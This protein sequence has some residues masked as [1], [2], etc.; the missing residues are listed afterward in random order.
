MDDLSF[1]EN[2]GYADNATLKVALPDGQ[3]CHISDCVNPFRF[4]DHCPLLYH[5]FESDEHG[6]LQ[7]S[8]E[9]TSTSSVVSLLRFCYTGGY[10]PIEQCAELF[11]LLQH[12]EIY[13]LASNFDVPELQLVAHGNFSCQIECACSLPTTP[14][15]LPETIRFVYKHFSGHELQQEHNLVNTL[16]NYCVSAYHYHKLG[17][18]AEF[19]KV[20]DDIPIFRQDLCRTNIARGFTDDSA[21]DIIRLRLES[22]PAPELDFHPTAAASET[23]P[24]EL[25]H[26]ANR[27]LQA[28]STIVSASRYRNK[29]RKMKLSLSTNNTTNRAS[30]DMCGTPTLV[31]RP[32]VPQPVRDWDSDTEA[33]CG[34]CTS[35][36]TA[37]WHRDEA[38][39][40][41]CHECW[42]FRRRNDPSRPISHRHNQGSRMSLASKRACRPGLLPG[43][44][45]HAE[46]LAGTSSREMFVRDP[47]KAQ[48]QQ[49]F[50]KDSSDEDEG[51]SVVHHPDSPVHATTD[52]P[53]SSPELIPS[54]PSGKDPVTHID[55]SSDDDW[56]ML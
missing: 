33:V 41:L 46:G 21:P 55:P 28:V 25:C 11:S 54:V 20:V 51:F 16:L 5:A 27:T 34:N 39:A 52:E 48:T 6:R 45:A 37:L 50:T 12:A 4:L 44:T 32:K 53:M 10:I 31:L 15:D 38:G 23:L 26:N 42:L 49:T 17:E 36:S 47:P 43:T 30:S 9:A 19:L 13:K 35:S 24:S 22:A 1:L 14:Q 7:A 8:I 2:Y 18:N 29:W 40:A 3:V 56:T